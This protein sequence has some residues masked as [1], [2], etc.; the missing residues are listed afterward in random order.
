MNIILFYSNT[1]IL[2][3]IF[4]IF[5][6]VYSS[7][8]C[9]IF[10]SLNCSCFQSNIDLNSTLPIK[11]YSHL[12]CQGNSLNEKTFRSPFGVDFKHQN[13][14]RTVTMEFFNKNSIEIQSNHFDPLA[15]LSSETNHDSQIDIFLRFNGFNHITFE[16]RSLTSAMFQKKHQNTRL[17]INLIPARNN[18]T[19]VNN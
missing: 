5:P 6:L 4:L 7:T 16:E 8:T 3:P 15:M 9:S 12:Y 18:L 13:H 19:Q 1:L 14:F 11:I 10:P 2:I 17:W